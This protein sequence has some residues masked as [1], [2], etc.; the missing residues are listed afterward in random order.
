M[1]DRIARLEEQLVDLKDRQD[2]V[3]KRAEEAEAER[4]ELKMA[5]QATQ[6]QLTWHR[7]TWHQLISL[8]TP[9]ELPDDP[10][11]VEREHIKKGVY[12]IDARLTAL[13]DDAR[14]FREHAP[15]D[16]PRA[17]KL[18]AIRRDLINKALEHPNLPLGLTQTATAS[19][20]QSWFDGDGPSDGYVRKIMNDIADHHDGF[21]IRRSDNPTKPMKLTVDL[22]ELPTGAVSQHKL[23]ELRKRAN[24]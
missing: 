11:D 23:K 2:K 18:T 3:E 9:A 17:A 13:E 19:Q 16:N 22:E 12:A 24:S 21:T 10:A 7:E 1:S 20:I 14:V 15:E 5:L 6:S 8:I 4:D